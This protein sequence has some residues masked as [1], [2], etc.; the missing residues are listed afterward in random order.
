MDKWLTLEFE[1]DGEVLRMG[2]GCAELPVNTVRGLE[3]AAVQLT[4][5]ENAQLDGTYLTGRRLSARIIEVIFT[6][7]PQDERLRRQVLRFFNPKRGG[8]LTVWSSQMN[9]MIDY[10]VESLRIVS[11]KTLWSLYG[12]ELTLYCA[13]PFFRGLSDF[14][15]NLAGVTPLFAF[16]LALHALRNGKTVAYRTYRQRDVFANDGDAMAGVLVRFIAERGEVRNPSFSNV[17]NGG[18]V[19]MGTEARPFVM[20]QGDVLEIDTRPRTQ[21]ITLNG[22]N[23][24]RYI[25][26]ASTTLLLDVGDNTL[27]YDAALNMANL[28]VYLYYTPLYL[29]LMI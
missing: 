25:N 6:I 19:T 2:S 23:V 12:I 27:E 14:G 5:I 11:R 8:R 24:Y 20:T 15:K 1:S 16:P 7:V 22:S 17:T 21:G 29:G 26:R 18:C 10:S 28:D 9:A 4:S 3:S 13:E